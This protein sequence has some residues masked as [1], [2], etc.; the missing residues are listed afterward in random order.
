[1][2]DGNDVVA[3][4]KAA[5]DA[6]AHARSGAGPAFIEAH[7]YRIQGHLEAEA[8]FL[9][10]GKYREKQEIDEWRSRD[11]IDRAR[12]RLTAAGA[13][14]KDLDAIGE[15]IARTVT[16]AVQFAKDSPPADNDLPFDLMFV[17]QRA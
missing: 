11:P 5:G 4:Y 13:K 6:V 3:V 16:E 9:A 7:T 1:V 15:R 8:L 12:Q 10:G 14:E 2:V 17:G